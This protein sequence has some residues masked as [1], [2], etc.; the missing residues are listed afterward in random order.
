[1]RGDPCCVAKFVVLQN[2]LCCKICLWTVG[3][4]LYEIGHWH[5]HVRSLAVSGGIC[6]PKNRLNHYIS[7]DTF[8]SRRMDHTVFHKWLIKQT[9]KSID[10]VERRQRFRN[11][12][13]RRLLQSII[14]S[15]SLMAVNGID[16]RFGY[17]SKLNHSNNRTR[18]QSGGSA[19]DF[20]CFL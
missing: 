19:A 13:K 17:C 9:E 8:R 5:L 20:P 2:L 6:Q 18:R 1:M 12:L 16:C 10:N 7:L 11:R 15:L 3:C 4:E 14:M